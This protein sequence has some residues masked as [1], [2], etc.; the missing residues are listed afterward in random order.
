ML[1]KNYWLIVLLALAFA[2]R[3]PT[4]E[5][6]S[7]TPAL[8]T[9][10][11][12][13]TRLRAEAGPEGRVIRE[14]P[15]GT[16][17]YDL[18][19]VSPFTT[20]LRLR[21]IWFDEPW[22][23]V[24]TEDG[25]IGWVYAGALHF[26]LNDNSE[27]TRLLIEKRLQTLFGPALADS[28]RAYR[29]AFHNIES[30]TDLAAVYQQGNFLRDTMARLMQDR[31]EVQPDLPDLFWLRQAM[32]G[33]MPQLV[34]EGTA[35][36]LFW[37]YQTLHGIATR[38]PQ[39]EDDDF[40]ALQIE[41][42]P[43]DSIEYFFPVWFLQTWDYGGSSLLGRGHHLRILEKSDQLLAKSPLFATEIRR[44]K[45]RIVNDISEPHVTYWETADKIVAELDAILQKDFKLLSAA[46]KI[47][48]QTRREQFVEPIRHSITVNEQA[49]GEE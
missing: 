40:V 37:N 1:Q 29:Q 44:L 20:R 18:G 16:T 43:E 30:A 45:A 12:D 4:D 23:K 28:I 31:I 48:L 7:A 19:E 22:L 34:A 32:P 26:D 5:T 35:Y 21:G 38:T 47:A 42:F 6:S 13:N 39:P 14:L 27:R 33:F 17:L 3:Q 41:L 8:F 46:D 25:A 2:C 36:Y 9:T 15:K 49:G 11:V 24:R 10:N